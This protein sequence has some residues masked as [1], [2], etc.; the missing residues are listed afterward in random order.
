MKKVC[1]IVEDYD[2][3]QEDSRLG[4]DKTVFD[5]VLDTA[6]TPGTFLEF[7]DYKMYTSS[8]HE[9]YEEEKGFRHYCELLAFDDSSYLDSKFIKGGTSLSYSEDE[10]A[11]TGRSF[12]VWKSKKESSVEYSTTEPKVSQ[13]DIIVIDGDLQLLVKEI[14]DGYPYACTYG[15]N[16]LP[17]GPFAMGAT[18]KVEVSYKKKKELSYD[19]KYPDGRL[20]NGEDVATIMEDYNEASWIS[21]GFNDTTFLIVL[22]KELKDYTHFQIGDKL[23]YIRFSMEY[24]KVGE[25]HHYRYACKL[26]HIHKS[27]DFIDPSLIKKGTIIKLDTSDKEF[28]KSDIIPAPFKLIDE[29]V[30]KNFTFVDTDKESEMVKIHAMIPEGSLIVPPHL[31]KE[32]AR[33]VLNKVLEP[34]TNKYD[35]KDF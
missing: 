16:L 34:N 23:A 10:T 12:I 6:L 9:V 1:K 35:K 18:A 30:L 15:N 5:V 22:D 32:W 2:G 17:D 13:G 20:V 8:I 26:S 28:G 7:G 19:W 25:E 29:E 4:I 27:T 24:K 31:I 21:P 3:I 11:I 14:I 33:V